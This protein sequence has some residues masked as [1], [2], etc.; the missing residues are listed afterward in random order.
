M[1]FEKTALRDG[2][3]LHRFLK[4]ELQRAGINLTPLML[5]QVDSSG[6]SV[7]RAKETLKELGFTE[8]QIA[9]HTADEPDPTLLALANN[10]NVEV[11]IFKIAVALGFDAPRAWTLVSMRATQSEDFGVQLVGPRSARSPKIARP[12]CARC[13]AVRLRITGGY[14][15]AGWTGRSRTAHQSH[16]HG[17]CDCQPYDDHL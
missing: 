12:R 14:R 11:L 6:K 8:G 3:I 1:D 17:L 15:S 5:V 10:E 9:T 7:D 16:S 13:T 2:T 4:E